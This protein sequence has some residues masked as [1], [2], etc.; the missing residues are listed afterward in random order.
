MLWTIN[1]YLYCLFF[2]AIMLWCFVWNLF[3]TQTL[4]ENIY[5]V[6]YLH[7]LWNTR[8]RL[9]K[10]SMF[11]PHVLKLVRVDLA[12]KGGGAQ[13][14]QQNPPLPKSKK[15]FDET[16]NSCKLNLSTRTEYRNVYIP[17]GKKTFLGL[18][19]EVEKNM[20]V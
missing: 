18:Y 19:K 16:S 4:S 9:A 13:N 7:L 14:P 6:I 17:Q 10:G 11:F 8:V 2:V 12:G 5:N 1:F 20:Y 3:R 15:V